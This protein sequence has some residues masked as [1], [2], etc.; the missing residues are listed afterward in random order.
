[1]CKSQADTWTKTPERYIRFYDKQ[2]KVRFTH[3]RTF[4]QKLAFSVTIQLHNSLN[5]DLTVFCEKK[6]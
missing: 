5:I 3:S 1:M 2:N 6:C 4:E